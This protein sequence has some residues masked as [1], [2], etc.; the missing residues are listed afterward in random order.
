V[1]L[2]DRALD[3]LVSSPGGVAW[4]CSS[5]ACFDFNG[6]GEDLRLLP[7]GLDG[8]CCL[9]TLLALRDRRTSSLDRA[10]RLDTDLV[11]EG[12]LLSDSL[13]TRLLED[14]REEESCMTLRLDADLL[15]S[16]C[17]LRL[18]DLLLLLSVLASF[19]LPLLLDGLKLLDDGCLV[20]RSRLE[21]LVPRLESLVPRLESLLPRLESLMARLESLLPKLDS[22]VPR[23]ESLVPRLES[24]LPRLESLMARLESLLPRLE[25]LIGFEWEIRELRLPPEWS[26][27]FLPLRDSRLV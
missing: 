11:R 1:L 24:L 9:A 18:G 14:V 2:R 23:L 8:D 6:D 16:G 12:A 27:S 20:D 4:D 5:T 21:S 17:R 7:C 15:R 13:A 22:L 19:I 26:L 3:S 10:F 25:S